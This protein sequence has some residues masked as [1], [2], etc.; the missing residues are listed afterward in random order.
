LVVE[1]EFADGCGETLPLPFTFL[2]PGP[3][4]VA[5][6]DARSGG[7]DGVRRSPQVMC[8]DVRH[9]DR[10]AGGQR[11][12]LRRIG[13]PPRG[14]VRLERRVVRIGHPQLPADPGPTDLDGVARPAVTGLLLLE[15]RQHVLGAHEGPVGEQPVV[16]VRQ[17][18]PAADGDQP[19]VAL[20]RQDRHTSIEAVRGRPGHSGTAPDLHCRADR[21]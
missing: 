12:E 10:L 6:S 7:P 15:Q 9:R 4:R 13:H 19:G 16:L 3:R 2:G 20:L 14:G 11:G 8:G 1:D 17:S 5:G 18:A 21:I